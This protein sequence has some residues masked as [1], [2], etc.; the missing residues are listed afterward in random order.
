MKH[1]LLFIFVYLSCIAQAIAE[2]SLAGSLTLRDAINLSIRNN[3]EIKAAAFRAEAATYG[4]QIATAGY[5]PQIAFEEAFAVSNAPTRTFMMKL[6]QSKFT[7]ND[8]QINNLNRPGS[9]HDFRTT[10]SITQPLFAPAVLPAMDMAKQ[11]AAK[12]KILSDAAKEGIA[13]E[14]FRIYL[15]VQRNREQ[16]KATALALTDARENLRLATVRNSAGTGLR[17]DELRARTHLSQAEQL[18]ITAQ[19]NLVL[20][21]MQLSVITGQYEDNL[22][23]RVEKQLYIPPVTASPDEIKN[24]AMQ[25]RTDLKISRTEVDKAKAAVKFAKSSYLPVIGASASYQLNSKEQPVGS[26]NDAWMAGINLNWQL[27]DGFRRSS[28]KKRATAEHS[29][30]SQMLENR[31]REVIYQ[32][33]ESIMRREESGKRL[34]M[35]RH[36]VRDAEETVRLVSRRFENSLSTMVELLDAQ[37]ALNQARAAEVNSEAEFALAGGKIFF[38]AGI[39]LKEILK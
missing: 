16:L 30:A 3:L 25:E 26:D 13:F 29:A 14:T 32:V 5:L 31:N 38:N 12:G 21:G 35:A 39:F 28:E 34:E 17:S 33:Q 22:A 18:M 4:S 24:I 23:D 8:F 19:N 27:F 7:E 6:D 20:A 37:T 11:D 2:D 1:H 10:L 9:W 36:A 15:D